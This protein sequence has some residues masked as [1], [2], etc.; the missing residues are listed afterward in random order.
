MTKGPL[1]ESAKR[2]SLEG[3]MRRGLLNE[4]AKNY[5]TEEIVRKG[6]TKRTTNPMSP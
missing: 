5:R 4:S 2:N 1:N 3:T 6:R